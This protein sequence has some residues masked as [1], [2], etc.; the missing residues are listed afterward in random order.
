[1][2]WQGIGMIRSSTLLIAIAGCTALIGCAG[3]PTATRTSQ[4]GNRD[5]CFLPSQVN[6]F[7]G[8]KD[9]NV[10]IQVGANRY[11]RLNLTGTCLNVNWDSRIGI[12]SVGGSTFVCEGFDA[13]LIV[14]DASGT[15]RCQISSIHAITK[16]Q[17]IAD[18]KR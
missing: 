9:G 10:D 11:Y 15:Q 16:D 12:R 17:F 1:M 7:T 4:A 3:E 18:T 6:G 5:Q 8:T 14:P 2:P 13:E